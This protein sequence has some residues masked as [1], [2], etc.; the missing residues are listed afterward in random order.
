MLPLFPL[1]E[2]HHESLYTLQYSE[3]FI[4][5]E[6]VSSHLIERI[7]LAV[8]ILQLDGYFDEENMWYYLSDEDYSHVSEIILSTRNHEVHIT[9]LNREGLMNST[10]PTW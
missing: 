2:Q 1:L 9:F 4:I 6:N 10:K 3:A 5:R 8:E 7:E